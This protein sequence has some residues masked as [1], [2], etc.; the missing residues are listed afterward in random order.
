MCFCKHVC[1]CIVHIRC[2]FQTRFTPGSQYII[3][4]VYEHAEILDNYPFKTEEWSWN[5]L[6]HSFSGLITLPK[7]LQEEKIFA[8]FGTECSIFD[9]LSN[10]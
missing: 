4:A 1:N 6:L 10:L 9:K 8:I 2:Q 5:L 7:P 3:Y